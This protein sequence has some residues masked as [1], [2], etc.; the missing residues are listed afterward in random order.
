MLNSSLNAV[1]V[2][3][4]FKVFKKILFHQNAYIINA[5]TKI[6]LLIIYKSNVRGCMQL[7][8]LQLVKTWMNVTLGAQKFG[9]RPSIS[10]IIC[11]CMRTPWPLKLLTILNSQ[12]KQL[13]Q[14]FLPRFTLHPIY[15]TTRPTIHLHEIQRE[16][17]A[18]TVAFDRFY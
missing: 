5:I 14:P 1:W 9:F 2:N 6:Y 3:W 7:G 4:K 11:P 18:G 12:P 15:P 13:F 17:G 8:S 10:L 16:G